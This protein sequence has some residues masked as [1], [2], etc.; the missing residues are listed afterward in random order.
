[1]IAEQARQLSPGNAEIMANFVRA[2][3]QAGDVTGALRASDQ[4]AKA[5]PNDPR[6]AMT[7]S[8]LCLRHGQV[9]KARDLLQRAI[10]LSHGDPEV[11]LL[12]A[13]VNLLA[14]KPGGALALLKDMRPEVG[15]PGEVM[16]FAAS[17][18]ATKAMQDELKEASE[19][20]RQVGDLSGVAE[21]PETGTLKLP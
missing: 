6:L 13:K 4:A 21:Y 20:I 15:Q 17:S 3:F 1:V 9:D 11:R 14:D 10:E 19:L 2:Q 8:R 16:L 18:Q 12:L 5:V 7:L